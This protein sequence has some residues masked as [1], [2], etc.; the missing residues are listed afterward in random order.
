MAVANKQV[1]VATNN[2]RKSPRLEKT[3]PEA[4]EETQDHLDV[5]ADPE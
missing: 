5:A 3:A 4:R 1:A 2:Q